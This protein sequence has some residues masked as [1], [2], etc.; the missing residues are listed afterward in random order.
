MN[1]KLKHALRKVLQMHHHPNDGS[2]AVSL[3]LKIPDLRTLNT[4]HSEKLLAFKMEPHEKVSTV[5]KKHTSYTKHTNEVL[6]Q[7]HTFIYEPS[8]WRNVKCKVRVTKTLL[9]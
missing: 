4:L 7:L 2:L 5:T 6:E 3:L 8:N 9:R 1:E